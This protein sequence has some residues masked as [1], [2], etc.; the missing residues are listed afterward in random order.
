MRFLFFSFFPKNLSSFYREAMETDR[1]YVFASKH[2]PALQ[3]VLDLWTRVNG[4]HPVLL[5]THDEEAAKVA[6]HIIFL[7][8]GPPNTMVVLNVERKVDV[9]E[10][11][12]TTQRSLRRDPERVLHE[13]I[14]LIAWHSTNQV[15]DY[16]HVAYKCSSVDLD[17]QW[18]GYKAAERWSFCVRLATIWKNNL[19]LLKQRREPIDPKSYPAA[20]EYIDAITLQEPSPCNLL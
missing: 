6:P 2:N 15:Y 4:N 19:R 5:L 18:K 8:Q 7:S 13:L 16:M 1:I 12:T 3:P 20:A 10:D 14:D 17:G 9:H 11:G